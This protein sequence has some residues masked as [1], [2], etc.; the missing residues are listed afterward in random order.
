MKIILITSAVITFVLTSCTT[1]KYISKNVSA[2]EIKEIKYFAPL[3]Y[4]SIIVEGN[5]SVPDDSLSFVSKALLDSVIRNNKDFRIEKR[6]DIN[7]LENNRKVENELGYLIQTITNNRKLDG[8]KLT[9]TIDSIM[10]SNKQR[11]VMASVTTG[12]GRN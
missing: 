1:N 3:A 2:T 4:V 9:P 11:F 5:K 12:F 8:V 10:K 7:E 6:F